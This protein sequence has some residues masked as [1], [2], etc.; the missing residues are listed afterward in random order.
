MPEIRSAEFLPK[1]KRGRPKKVAVQSPPAFNNPEQPESVDT[2]KPEKPRP[3]CEER[4]QHYPYRRV[5]W[6]TEPQYAK[7]HRLGIAILYDKDKGDHI[8]LMPVTDDDGTIR[9]RYRWVPGPAPYNYSLIP[10]EPAAIS[11]LIEKLKI[12]RD[13]IFGGQAGATQVE[14]KVVQEIKKEQ[15]ESRVDEMLKKYKG[16]I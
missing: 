3:K 4:P 12:A 11:E 2:P 8:I 1:K 9:W 13:T 6:G 5:V 15:A 16:V 10:I 14:V 7:Y